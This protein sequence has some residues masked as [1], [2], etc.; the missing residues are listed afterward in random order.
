MYLRRCYLALIF[1]FL[2]G[3]KDG[4]VA[5]WEVPNREPT[6]IFPYRADYL[7][8]QDQAALEKGILV[9]TPGEL[10]GLLEDYLS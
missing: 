1:V 10:T 2:L 7:P 3:V 6:C 9:R 4:F 8:P 5:L